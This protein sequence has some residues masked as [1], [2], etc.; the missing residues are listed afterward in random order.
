MIETVSKEPGTRKPFLFGPLAGHG[1]ER[2]EAQ[3]D[4]PIAYDGEEIG[5]T[6]DP[7]YLGD[8][9]RVLDPE[10]NFVIELRNAESAAI[11]STE[12]GYAYVIMPL[13]RE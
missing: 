7:K 5:I 8:F 12:D 4:L 6:L 10:Q 13:A 3:V 9:L 2:G 11:C 1:A